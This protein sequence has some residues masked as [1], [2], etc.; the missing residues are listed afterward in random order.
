MAT[1]TMNKSPKKPVLVLLAAMIGSFTA[2]TSNVE[3]Q[4]LFQLLFNNEA[5]H[6]QRPRWERLDRHERRERLER[7]VRRDRLKRPGG[8][9]RKVA[10]R[11]VIKK[12]P[13]VKTAIYYT[14]RPVALKKTNFSNLAKMSS[15]L[16]YYGPQTT[17]I[18]QNKLMFAEALASVIN[19]NTRARKDIS[20]ALI[21][22]YTRHPEFMWVT[23]LR[24]NADA[25]DMLGA[26]ATAEK[27]G[28]KNL[29]YQVDLPK[30]STLGEAHD[31]VL[32]KLI[33]F[34]IMLSLRAVRY[35]LDA[36][37]GVINPNKLSGYHDFPGKK[38]KAA[39]VLSK[40][41]ASVNRLPADA[42]SSQNTAG[43]IQTASV[44]ASAIPVV[45]GVFES[46]NINAPATY[47]LSLHP[48]HPSFAR[49]VATLSELRQTDDDAIFIAPDTFV[50]PGNSHVEIPNIVKAIKRRG[51]EKLLKKYA[52][53]LFFYDGGD[54]YTT[55]LVALV[56]GFQKEKNL[57]PDGIIGRNS[58]SKMSDTPVA[59][60][61]N[62]IILA[63]E[64]LRWHPRKFGNRHVFINQPAYQATYLSGGQEKLSMRVVVG[65]SANQTNF[66]YDKIERVVYNP[67]WGVP[68]SILVNE[69]LPKLR[70]NPSYLDQRGYEV[71]T[72]SGQLISSA[73]VDWYGVGEKF[74]YNVR[75]TPGPKNALGE[76]KILFPNKHNIYMHDTPSKSLFNRSKRALSHGCV[77]LKYP[78]KM[79]AAVLG[80]NM[81]VIKSRLGTGRNNTQKLKQQVPVYVAYFTAWP[82]AD[83]KVQFYSDMYGRDK[84]LLKALKKAGDTRIEVQ[85]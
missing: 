38:L 19:I 66:F 1:D 65:K 39:D 64:R 83:G 25:T 61:L 77:R 22:H 9:V 11:R 78:R 30:F 5:R 31:Q 15:G 70:K 42:V 62:R 75:Q 59:I 8:Q 37:G 71:T 85:G 69:M 80:T 56:K 72:T 4:T 60:K 2:P 40:L 48:A 7:S 27:Y 73:S 6:N 3:A 84:H 82:N 23:D 76:L 34:E 49:F 51:S 26:L 18:D 21:A 54:V 67:Y 57:K 63:M 24:P 44:D 79:A 20:K 52:L 32:S 10:E 13:R 74:G 81:S 29:D 53:E 14:Y 46:A 35:A 68:R 45:S 16:G 17:D 55:D 12:K 50:R 28:L 58:V 33:K 47:L 41:Y 43:S 36:N